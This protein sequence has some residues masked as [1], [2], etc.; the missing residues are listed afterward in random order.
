MSERVIVNQVLI[1]AFDK[2]CDAPLFQPRAVVHSRV[3]H[4]PVDIAIAVFNL[5]NGRLA[6]IQVFE[7]RLHQVAM[8]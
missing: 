8:H 4:Q 7:M 1:Q 2:S 6:A 3:V 5:G